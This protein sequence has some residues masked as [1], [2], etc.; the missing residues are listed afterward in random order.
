ML[1]AIIDD[2]LQ[3]DCAKFNADQARTLLYDTLM[4]LQEMLESNSD[5]ICTNLDVTKALAFR[6]HALRDFG[7]TV[8]EPFRN[9]VEDELVRK[10]QHYEYVIGG[11]IYA[12]LSRSAIDNTMEGQLVLMAL[13][14]SDPDL[15][16]ASESEISSYLAGYNEEQLKGIANNVKGIYH[17]LLWVEQYNATHTDT[18]AELY[19]ATNHPGAD[20]RIVDTKTGEVVAE[21]QLK[22]TDSVAYVEE[23]QVRY[24]EIEIIATD[25][26]ANRM[27][28]VEASDNLNSDLTASTEG[29]INALADN[30]LGDRALE[31]AE[32]AATIA[33]GQELVKML[34]GEKEFPDAIKET[35]TKSGT[36]GATMAIAAYLF[37][38]K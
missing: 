29:G 21:Y 26:V 28:G 15:A 4:P 14:R 18:H 8:I 1:I 32:L 25:E 31:G 5:A 30:T 13:R 3:D 16:N 10:T 24:T 17:E 12:L 19:E 6:D 37:S 36:A 34:Q 22:A 9:F 20:V 11:A 27:E 33:T 38:L 23:H 7:P 35:I 2:Y